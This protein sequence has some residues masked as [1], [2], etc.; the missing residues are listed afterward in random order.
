MESTR[1]DYP[2]MLP[3]G[4]VKQ[5]RHDATGTAICGTCGNVATYHLFRPAVGVRCA[6]CCETYGTAPTVTDPVTLTV[7]LSDAEHIPH[8]VIATL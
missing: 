4:E 1:T 8:P 5:A 2:I 6:S 3:S 7:N